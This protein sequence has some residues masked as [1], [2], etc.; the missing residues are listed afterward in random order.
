MKSKN[1]QPVKAM[2]YNA[3][4]KRILG[5]VACL[6]IVVALEAVLGRPSWMLAVLAVFAVLY[7]L[8]TVRVVLPLLKKGIAKRDEGA[9]KL[10]DLGL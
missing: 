4:R 7:S 1:K 3:I 2:S 5:G 9:S 8:V 6:W 10:P